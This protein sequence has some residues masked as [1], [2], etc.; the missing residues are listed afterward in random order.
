MSTCDRMIII[1]NHAGQLQE[2]NWGDMLS[3]EKWQQL[4]LRTAKKRGAY[5]P[6]HMWRKRLTLWSSETAIG[7]TASEWCVCVCSSDNFLF[8]GSYCRRFRNISPHSFQSKM[9]RSFCECKYTEMDHHGPSFLSWF[10]QDLTTPICISRF[11]HF[12]T[13]L[14]WEDVVYLPALPGRG[15]VERSGA[16]WERSLWKVSA[17]KF[18]GRPSCLGASW[19][20]KYSTHETL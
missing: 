20:G 11:L 2:G 5:H 10:W 1:R 17:S 8:L 3:W 18:D 12:P 4:R 15:L 9:I 7:L 13:W 14:W 19:F 16:R 6:R